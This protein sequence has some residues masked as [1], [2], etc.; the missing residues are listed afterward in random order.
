MIRGEAQHAMIILVRRRVR[1]VTFDEDRSTVR[2]GHGPQVMA[3]LRNLASP[4]SA[5]A[6]PPTSPP[7]YATTPAT[8]SAP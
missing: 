4:R 1:D 5:S 8:D 3:A 7:P 2:T 6:A